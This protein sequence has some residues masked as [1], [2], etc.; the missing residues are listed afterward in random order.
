[1]TQV[2][3]SA[4]A[5]ELAAVPPEKLAASAKPVNFTRA[6]WDRPQKEASATARRE[7]TKVLDFMASFEACGYGGCREPRLSR[8]RL[9]VASPRPRGKPAKAD[10][11]SLSGASTRRF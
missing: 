9:A 10:G 5:P 2:F 6:A 8:S 7:E 3:A 4:S 11:R 1:M